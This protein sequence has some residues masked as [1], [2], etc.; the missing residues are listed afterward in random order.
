MCPC[1]YW[2]NDE[3]VGLFEPLEPSRQRA[4]T[5][6]T[7]EAIN[8]EAGENR[9]AFEQAEHNPCH[10]VATYKS[11]SAAPGA[12]DLSALSPTQQRDKSGT[13]STLSL[14]VQHFCSACNCW[15]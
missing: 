11:G 13:M 5:G 6:A 4:R 1:K 10:K 14:L 8:S 12:P 15:Q 7:H 2:C 9:Q 3:M